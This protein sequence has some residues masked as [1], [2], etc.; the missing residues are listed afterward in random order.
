MKAVEDIKNYCLWIAAV[1]NM[2][3]PQFDNIIITC[4][5]DAGAWYDAIYPNFS[6][7]PATLAAQEIDGDLATLRDLA[8]QLG[9]GTNGQ[10]KQSITRL[11]ADSKRKLETLRDRTNALAASLETFGNK[12]RDNQGRFNTGLQNIW[13]SLQEYYQSANKFFDEVIKW[14]NASYWDK[15]KFYEAQ[16]NL[17]EVRAKI[18]S[19][20]KFGETFVNGW[21]KSGDA[22]K[23]TDNL[24]QFWTDISGKLEAVGN[25]IES[26][27]EAAQHQLDDL[28]AAVRQFGQPAAISN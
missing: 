7:M 18:T 21:I 28:K 6:N 24:A 8:A 4:K 22:V 11:A 12:V 5:T 16:G 27:P 9:S 1:S 2:D 26:D 23:G 20:E 25:K 17:K 3:E 13:S 15:D 14:Q 19:Y 10:I